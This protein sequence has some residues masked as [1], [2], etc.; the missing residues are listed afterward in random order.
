MRHNERRS[1]VLFHKEKM[2]VQKH[3]QQVKHSKVTER[4]TTLSRNLAVC[5]RA[6]NH[7]IQVCNEFKNAR[8]QNIERKRG[9]D[10]EDAGRDE[11]E[12]RERRQ[13]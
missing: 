6:Q 3:V 12:R 10:E 2:K 7:T 1:T 5:N 9:G 13:E 11:E 4:N 8:R